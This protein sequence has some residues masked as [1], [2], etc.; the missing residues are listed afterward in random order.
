M[1]QAIVFNTT[2][3]SVEIIINNGPS[4][5]LAGTG[6]ATGYAPASLTA[7]YAAG[8]DAPG[9]FGDQNQLRVQFE[10]GSQPQSYAVPINPNKPFDVQLYVFSTHVF[11]SRGG[12]IE[13]FLS[14]A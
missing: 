5:L 11:V 14:A 1:P 3:E 7:P 2:V 8:G 13:E 10:S 12:W 9:Q 6:P 4:M